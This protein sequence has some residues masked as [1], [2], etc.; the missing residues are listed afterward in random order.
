MRKDDRSLHFSTSLLVRIHSGRV[1]PASPIGLTTSRTQVPLGSTVLCELTRTFHLIPSS[2]CMA[3]NARSGKGPR[4][5][6]GRGCSRL[7]LASSSPAPRARRCGQ[8]WFLDQCTVAASC[9]VTKSAVPSLHELSRYTCKAEA[10]PQFHRL[11]TLCHCQRSPISFRRPLVLATS[12]S[13]R[14][15]PSAPLID[16]P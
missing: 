7:Q 15:E 9:G 4:T 2:W 14:A 6:L 8:K 1:E 5:C 13:R 16:R 12:R 11:H 10:T 3:K